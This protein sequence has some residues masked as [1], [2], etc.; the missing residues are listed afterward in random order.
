MMARIVALK[1]FLL[2]LG[3]SSSAQAKFASWVNHIPCTSYEVKILSCKKREFSNLSYLKRRNFNHTKVVLKGVLTKVQVV[4]TEPLKCYEEQ[5]IDL[6][7]YKK[8][9]KE[10]L[11]KSQFF[12]EEMKCL[13]VMGKTLKVV[14]RKSFCDTPGALEIVDCYEGHLQSS[15]NLIL[16]KKKK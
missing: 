15:E 2:C 3:L 16:T 5:K 7:R 4:N 9:E 6:S 12:I 10:V 14:D 8:I 1:V 13:D 11:E